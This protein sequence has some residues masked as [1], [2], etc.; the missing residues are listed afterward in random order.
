M[1]PGTGRAVLIG[2][3]LGFFAVGGFCAIVGL[4]LGLPPTAAVALGAFTGFWG[5]PGFGGTMGFVLHESHL[6]DAAEADHDHPV[7]SSTT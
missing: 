1:A 4:A 5:G 7:D 2:T 3:V 6:R